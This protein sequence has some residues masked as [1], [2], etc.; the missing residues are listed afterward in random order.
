MYRTCLIAASCLPMLLISACSSDSQVK[1]QQAAAEETTQPYY[2]TAGYIVKKDETGV[3]VVTDMTKAELMG[4][5]EEELAALLYEAQG[6]QF[7]FT[8]MEAIPEETTAALHIGQQ[9][10]IQHRM[11]GLSNPVHGGEV[12]E[13]EIKEES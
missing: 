11:L 12:L 13:I 6:I 3:G 9:V 10:T 2:T 4:K 1:E 7:D 5:N 8:D